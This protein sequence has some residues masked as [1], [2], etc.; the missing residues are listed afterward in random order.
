ML[1]LNS[2]FGER[3]NAFALVLTVESRLS[4][5]R[6]EDARLCDAPVPTHEKFTNSAPQEKFRQGLHQ[7]GVDAERTDFETG[8]RGL[9]EGGEVVGLPDVEKNI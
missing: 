7:C 3:E 8:V 2:R 9:D 1:W 6:E 5:E 4:H